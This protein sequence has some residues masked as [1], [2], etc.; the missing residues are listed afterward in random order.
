MPENATVI[1]D[2]GNNSLENVKLLGDRKYIGSIVL[3]DHAGLVDLHV[4]ID[5]LKETE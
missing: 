1:F 5:S 4:G 2:R 3:S